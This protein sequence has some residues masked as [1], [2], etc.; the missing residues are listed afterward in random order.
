MCV[1]HCTIPELIT[2]P[3]NIT[4]TPRHSTSFFSLCRSSNS[5]TKSTVFGSTLNEK[6][7][8]MKFFRVLPVLLAGLLVSPTLAEDSTSA[9]GLQPDD[10]NLVALCMKSQYVGN[11]P[12][13]APKNDTKLYTTGK[14]YV[15]WDS[16][17]WNPNSTVSIQL[18]YKK[19]GLKGNV[20]YSVSN[21]EC[22]QVEEEERVLYAVRD[23]HKGL[24][25]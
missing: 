18:N 19:S 4:W 24:R 6:I 11:G 16:G 22:L 5:S 13:C 12:F 25:S 1:E 2:A 15:S 8:T 10:N 20:A 7:V 3:G 17:I 23:A 14:Y 21:H 9:D